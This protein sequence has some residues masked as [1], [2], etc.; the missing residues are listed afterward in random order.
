MSDAVPEHTEWDDLSP[1][2][3]LVGHV[4]DEVLAPIM[5]AHRRMEVCLVSATEALLA[6]GFGRFLRNIPPSRFRQSRQ[7]IR[8]A[9]GMGIAGRGGGRAGALER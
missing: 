4:L 2:L 7:G 9:A 3:V 1:D 5:T 6:T 8:R